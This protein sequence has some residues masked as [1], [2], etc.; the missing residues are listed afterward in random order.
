MPDLPESMRAVLLTGPR[1]FTQIETA[2]PCGPTAGRTIVRV[3]AGGIC[4]S[5]GP[6]AKGAPSRFGG[7]SHPAGIAPAG[8][9][10]HEIAGEVV[11]TTD[12][13]LASGDAV[14]GWATGFDGMAEYVD[15]DSASLARY[16][17]R[18]TP[19]EAVLLQPLACVIHAVDRLGDVS[20]R[21]CTVLGLGPIGLLFA[22]VLASAGATVEGVDPVDRRAVAAACGLSAAHHCPSSAW[23]AGLDPAQRP[24]I[25]VEA[26]GHQTATLNHAI[27]GVAECGLVLYFGVPDEDIYPIDME[28]VVRKHLTLMAGGTLERRRALQRADVYLGEHA[29]LAPA[30]LTHTL[31]VSDADAAFEA[32]LTARSGRHKVV[33]T[34]DEWWR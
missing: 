15:T 33:L 5:D 14:V 7:A 30:L 20:G 34:M 4:G 1:R 9:P 11:A 25:V 27:H 12:P 26:V 21:R 2:T 22:H 24:D 16:S 8:S 3:R 13:E 32:A 28:Q 6:F 18:W 19:A 17:D 31:P 10:M 29:G 23:A